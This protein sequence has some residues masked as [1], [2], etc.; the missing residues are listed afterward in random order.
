MCALCTADGFI[1]LQMSS[2]HHSSFLL[3]KLKRSKLKP[4]LLRIRL[5][6]PILKN[7]SSPPGVLPPMYHL[8]APNTSRKPSLLESLPRRRFDE[9]GMGI[10]APGLPATLPAGDAA[11]RGEWIATLEC[12]CCVVFAEAR[13]PEEEFDDVEVCAV[14]CECECLVGC[15]C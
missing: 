2:S 3:Y 5:I 1:N 10:P 9:L 4:S 13:A 11:P 7:F 14:W 15:G 8:S 6:T 12:D